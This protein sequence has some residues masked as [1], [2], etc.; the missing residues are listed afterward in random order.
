MA[1]SIPSIVEIASLHRGKNLFHL[2]PD[3][4]ARRKIAERLGEPGIDALEGAFVLIP[5][6]GGVDLSLHV[7]ARVNRL[8]VASLE[9]LVEEVD[10]R[11]SIRFERDFQD[12]GDSE[13]VDR[14]REPLEGETLDLT[15]ILVQ[16][17][18]VSLSPHPR[19]EGAKS[20]AEGYRDPV[21]LSP[22]SGLKGIVDG[23]A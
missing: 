15:E 11:Y 10:E 9:P 14:S 16:H 22:F 13:E 18:S 21:N 1:D 20:L 23:D 7:R 17:L 5:F 4:Q 6:G 8:C 3:E 12:D 19:K 2:S